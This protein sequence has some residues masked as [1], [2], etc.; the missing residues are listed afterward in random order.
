MKLDTIVTTAINHLP[1]LPSSEGKYD[2]GCVVI[3][4]TD[5]TVIG[6][7]RASNSDDSD[8]P[9]YSLFDQYVVYGSRTARTS[10]DI[11][12]N[13][14]IRNVLTALVDALV[15]REINSTYE[16]KPTLI[17][18]LIRFSSGT[19]ALSIVYTPTR[20]P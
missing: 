7:A 19:A 15:P 5:G 18:R 20:T 10:T 3:D 4:L 12:A 11:R 17:V 14:G 6:S 1:S 16:P 9:V 8:N 2:A 13:V